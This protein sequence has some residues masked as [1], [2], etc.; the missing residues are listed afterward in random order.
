MGWLESQAI[1]EGRALEIAGSTI[2]VLGGY[3]MVGTAVCREL[4]RLEPAALVVTSLLQSEAEAAV[5]HLSA[6]HP[7]LKTRLVPIWGNLFVRAALKDKSRADVLN[8]PE[9]RHWVYEDL[10]AEI[11]E[12][13]VSQSF[14][15]K[16]LTGATEEAPGVVP[17]GV[18]DCVNTATAL[19]YQDIYTSAAEVLDL[20]ERSEEVWRLGKTGPE[21][22]EYVG[23]VERL[24]ASLYIP[25]LVRHVQILNEAMRAAGTKAYVK[26]GTAGTGGM[27]LNI[28][29]THGEEK[30]SRVLLSK[31]ALA[32][33]HSTLLFLMARTPGGPVVKEVKPTAA[34]AWKSIGA[35]PIRKRGREIPLFDCPP[36]RALQL[37]PDG[38]FDL[39]SHG[40]GDRQ[41]GV[42]ESVYIDTGE[43]GFFSVAE[44]TAITSLGQ[45]EAITP[46]EIA[47]TVTRE[48]GGINT[49]KDIVGALD[50][51]VMGPTYRA[52]ALRH[53]AIA[54]ARRLEAERGVSSIAFE[55]LG[56]PRLSKLLFEA[57]FL[58]TVAGTLEA[59]ATADAEELADRLDAAIRTDPSLRIPAI[60]IGIPI[61]RSDGKSLLCADRTERD[62]AWE[63]QPWSVT[64]DS[65]DRW[66][67]T[68][69]IDLRAQNIARW[70]ARTKRFLAL[71]S[72]TPSPEADSSSQFDREGSDPA[73]WQVQPEIDPGEIVGWI[74]STEEAG[75]RMK[76]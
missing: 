69:W 17:D 12:G 2:A 11:S 51:A 22:G 26:V 29:Y 9:Y 21:L 40:G 31:A 62:H 67:D 35:G 45:M 49:G 63:R 10:L 33:A 57:H 18:V 36:E 73:T 56:P 76:M 72:E 75:A 60:S 44:F 48:L 24:L 61:L 16:V 37:D 3:G 13:T 1:N 23:A 39:R 50:G 19:A 42:L 58:R 27:G 43:N 64:P 74:F 15:A 4:L 53:R 6:E 28:P 68:E 46:E 66:A 55:I 32:G 41:G 54:Y 14:L 70:K 20:Y 30:P 25:Q 71:A 5:A 47:Q 52:G 34:I 8:N 59:V 38:P 65:I 7:G